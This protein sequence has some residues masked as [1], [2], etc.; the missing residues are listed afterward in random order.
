VRITLATASPRESSTV[1][2]GLPG[3]TVKSRNSAFRYKGSD[4]DVQEVAKKLNVAAILLGRITRHGD[5][6]T[7][8]AELVDAGT[9]AISGEQY[10]RQLSNVFT[11]QEDI[12]KGIS[13]QL[14]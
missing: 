13:E 10:D 14:R 3:V 1:Y 11:L 6:L 12:S 5:N 4:V 8:S 9:T 7:V 2:P